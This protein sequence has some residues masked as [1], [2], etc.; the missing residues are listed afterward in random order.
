MLQSSAETAC[1][2]V[3]KKRNNKARIWD[4]YLAHVG[5]WWWFG[6]RNSSSATDVLRSTGLRLQVQVI[7]TDPSRDVPPLPGVLWVAAAGVGGK[8]TESKPTVELV[9]KQSPPPLLFG[10]LMQRQN[11]VH[12]CELP[13]CCVSHPWAEFSYIKAATHLRFFQDPYHF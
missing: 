7:R 11:K 5:W 3:S 9:P 2:Q 6:G 13:W 8:G 12:Y 10:C 4:H 1:L